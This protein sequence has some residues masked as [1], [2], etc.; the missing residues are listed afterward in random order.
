MGRLSCYNFGVKEYKKPYLTIEQQIAKLHG[1]GLVVSNHDAAFHAL[2][3]IGYY[4][5]SGYWYPMRKSQIVSD[6]A[7]STNIQVLDDFR[8]GSDFENL[9]ALYVYDKRLRTHLLDLL[10]RLEIALRANITLQMGQ[11]SPWAYRQAEFLNQKFVK[12]IPTGKKESSFDTF[13]KRFDEM[14]DKSKSEFVE[15]FKSE[16]ST[17]LPIWAAVELWDF[18]M[19]SKFYSGLKYKDQ[20]AIAS[21]YN[22]QKR[23][24]ILTSWIRTLADIRNICAHHGR[25]WNRAIASQPR[26]P[27]A[28]ENPILDHLIPDTVREKL[29]GSIAIARYMQTIV[30]PDSTWGSKLID[31]NKTFPSAPGIN[32]SSSGYP[33]G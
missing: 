17:P 3:N 5:L 18:G 9:I 6:G 31:L 27:V 23:P 4:R 12:D 21:I 10:E 26:S 11:Y 7:G 30:T 22:L 33:D 8:D 29:Y 19:L 25:L 28:G 32:F 2:K 13:V 1:R 24:E 16:Y 20:I 14:V 15:H